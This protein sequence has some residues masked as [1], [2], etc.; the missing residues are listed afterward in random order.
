MTRT[1]A[2]E[3]MRAEQLA[4]SLVDEYTAW[5]GKIS[6]GQERHTV[7]SDTLDFVNFRIETAGSCLVLLENRKAA[8]AL[9]LCRALL[10]NYLLLMLMCR[11]TKFFKLE[12]TGLKG[13]D[14]RARLAE[15]QAEL[16][17]LQSEG[18]AA[19]LAVE[20][21]PRRSGHI[22]YVFEGLKS[23]DTPGFRI[24]VHYFELGAYF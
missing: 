2:E 16:D 6:Y 19:C 23:P 11:G 14:F 21:Y 20:E 22:M 5:G 4:R 13:A 10:E 18:T 7:Y 15:K 24:P 9:G 17:Q 1:V 12:N 3:I 8:D